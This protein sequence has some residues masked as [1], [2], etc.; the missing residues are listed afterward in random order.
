MLRSYN[1]TVKLHTL[2][3]SVG[4]IIGPYTS[5]SDPS[6]RFRSR[7]VLALLLRFRL[8]I[9]VQPYLVFLR[10]VLL[11]YDFWFQQQTYVYGPYV[12]P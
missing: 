12:I 2:R 8:Y 4:S 5:G 3:L 10:H 1:C 9:F 11:S 6:L 7:P